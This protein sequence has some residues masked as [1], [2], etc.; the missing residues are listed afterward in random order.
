MPRRIWGGGARAQRSTSST[1]P[2]QT[3]DRK[4]WRTLKRPPSPPSQS[5]PKL[6]ASLNSGKLFCGGRGTF[7]RAVTAGGASRPWDWP[8]GPP[9]RY[10]LGH[11][12]NRDSCEC[13][14]N[15]G[16]VNC[17][18]LTEFGVRLVVSYCIGSMQSRQNLST[19]LHCSR[20]FRGLSSEVRLEVRVHSVERA[21]YG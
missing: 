5:S 6:P 12:S 20:W 8:F 17:N 15:R 1:T 14:P 10:H 16:H 9:S 21:L 18:H 19:L 2:A 4:L 13:R 11:Y 3:S 7:V